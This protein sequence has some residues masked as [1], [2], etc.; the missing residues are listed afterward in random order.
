M[1]L[2]TFIANREIEKR[3]I[4]ISREG[5]DTD[6]DAVQLL[7]DAAAAINPAV[8]DVARTLVSTINRVGDV[9]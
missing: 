9:T 1:T 5:S 4:E 7:L 2:M 3:L 6:D 8:Q